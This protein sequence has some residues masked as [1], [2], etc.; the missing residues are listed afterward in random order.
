MFEKRNGGTFEIRQLE[1][2]GRTIYG[3]WIVYGSLSHNLGGF[4]ER[5]LPGSVTDAITSNG[6]NAVLNHDDNQHVG[7][8]AAGTLR[9]F[10]D[11]IGAHAEIKLPDT[12]YVRDFLALND[13]KRKEHRGMSFAFA[14]QRGGE[15]WLNENGGRVREIA[16]AKIQHVSPVI[17]PAYE[18]TSFSVRDLSGVDVDALAGVLVAVK[19]NL[20][21]SENEKQVAKYVEQMLRAKLTHPLLSQAQARADA[22]LI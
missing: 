5:F 4:V 8:Q 14:P 19:K 17:N 6:I 13:G 16:K 2:E 7:S 11:S 15:S 9:L 21:L 3:T 10:E 20:P 1:G 12:S 22:L 18:A